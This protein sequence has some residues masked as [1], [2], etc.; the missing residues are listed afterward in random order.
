MQ[1]LVRLTRV[2]ACKWSRFLPLESGRARNRA[3]VSYNR[4]EQLVGTVVDDLT[5]EPSVNRPKIKIY[6]SEIADPYLFVRSCSN[7]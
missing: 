5:A 2:P 6:T 7:F 3:L 4:L 1:R